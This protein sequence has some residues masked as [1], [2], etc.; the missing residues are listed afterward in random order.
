MFEISTI[1][2]K[3]TLVWK[4]L[5]YNFL[6]SLLLAFSNKENIRNTCQSDS[7]L[8]LNQ[9]NQIQTKQ[10]SNSSSNLRLKKV[11]VPSVRVMPPEI[12]NYNDY[13]TS[14]ANTINSSSGVVSP[15][16]ICSINVIKATSSSISTVATSVSKTSHSTLSSFSKNDSRIGNRNG[17]NQPSNKHFTTSLTSSG[18][19]VA[20]RSSSLWSTSTQVSNGYRGITYWGVLIQW[21]LRFHTAITMYTVS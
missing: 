6:V 11:I 7:G 9:G 15:V 18:I 12:V 19:S 4:Q 2:K 13:N 1:N 21:Y 17:Q 20:S 14:I 8:C 10:G 5:H 16:P 3:Q